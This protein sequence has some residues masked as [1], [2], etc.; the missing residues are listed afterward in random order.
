[1]KLKMTFISGNI[2]IS[3]KGLNAKGSDTST[4][5]GSCRHI[6]TKLAEQ[7]VVAAAV[8]LTSVVL[9]A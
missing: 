7:E 2:L 9:V 4:K 8:L 3:L 5:N 1:M 6:Y